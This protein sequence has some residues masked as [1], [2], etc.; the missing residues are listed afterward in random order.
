[1]STNHAQNFHKLEQ[2]FDT[3]KQQVG[4]FE[5]KIIGVAA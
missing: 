1:M 3:T 5:K 4:S 2:K